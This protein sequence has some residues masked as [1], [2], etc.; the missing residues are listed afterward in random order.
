VLGGIEF[1]KDVHLIHSKLSYL[2]IGCIQPASV[3][4]LVLTKCDFY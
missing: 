2:K 4:W 1:Y 3:D